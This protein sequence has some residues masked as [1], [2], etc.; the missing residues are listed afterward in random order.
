MKEN[1]FHCES[2]ELNFIEGPPNGL[3]ILLLHGATKNWQSFSPL[4]NDLMAY[5]HVLAIDFRGHGKS[6][7]MAGAYKLQDYLMDTQCFIMEYIKQPTIILGHSL[8]GMIGL[9]AAA[10]YPQLVSSLIIIDAPLTTASLRKLAQEQ[11][12]FANQLIQWLKISKFLNVTSF[13]NGAI[14]ESLS[15]CDP[16]MLHAIINDFEATFHQ[17]SIEELFPKIKCPILLIRGNTIRGSLVNDAEVEQVKTL[18]PKLKDIKLPH[19]GHSPI[20]QDKQLILKEIRA[21]LKK[22]LNV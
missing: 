5:L 11:G 16:D 10:K 2:A 4:I 9:M 22:I 15:Q 3:P 7:H 18:L 19:A 20:R 6:K 1:R 21:F 8:G 13:N 14:P 17:Y 12:A